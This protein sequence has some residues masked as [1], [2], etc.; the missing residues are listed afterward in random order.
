L[1][2]VKKN[3]SKQSSRHMPALHY[4][5]D[6]MR[7]YRSSG[8]ASAANY[9]SPHQLIAMLL[10]G[11]LERIAQARGCMTRRE[12]SGKLRAIAGA[13][14]IVEY[15][16]M[17]LDMKAGGDIARNLNAL[18]GY[19]LRRLVQANAL[20]DAAMLDEVASLLRTIKSAWDAIPQA[21][22]AQH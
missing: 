12:L 20:D 8:A 19:M 22:Q 15:L 13:T 2:A 5:H 3:I 18:Y 16:Q 17:Q 14:S 6:A 9:A 7:Q 21:S 11:A 10:N 1:H 4:Q